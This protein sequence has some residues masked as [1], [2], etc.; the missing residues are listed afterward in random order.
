MA[1]G[2]PV[3]AAAGR[4]VLDREEL[5]CGFPISRGGCAAAQVRGAP[6]R[7]SSPRSTVARML[8][9][10]L[11]RAMRP[12]L[13]PSSPTTSGVIDQAVG[14]RPG[15]GP[16]LSQMVA[17]DRCGPGHWRLASPPPPRMVVSMFPRPPAGRLAE[18]EDRRAFLSPVRRPDSRNQPRS[19]IGCVP[20][21]EREVPE[22]SP[23]PQGA[24]H[25]GLP[26]VGAQAQAR[27]RVPFAVP[28]PAPVSARLSR[29]LLR[30]RCSSAGPRRRSRGGP[31]L[32][33][34]G[35]TAPNPRCLGGPWQPGPPFAGLDCHPAARPCRPNSTAEPT[36]SPEPFQLESIVRQ[37]FGVAIP[38]SSR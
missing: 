1:A 21:F 17:R 38:A 29:F 16:L 11:R 27:R 2:G 15:A 14:A 10:P 32:P 12:K 6:D 30:P 23:N 24:L 13:W 35:P 4:A 18:L 34:V 28:G 31:G 8:P 9:A 37:G 36:W 26:F 22:S 19:N 7:R 3:H 20:R 33:E 5:K 25:L